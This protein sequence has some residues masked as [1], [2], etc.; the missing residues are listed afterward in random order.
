MRSC[1]SP[2]LQS[3]YRGSPKT[4]LLHDRL[5]NMSFLRQSTCQIFLGRL[6]DFHYFFT[7]QKYFIY[8]YIFITLKITAESILYRS[9]NSISKYHR[10]FSR[11]TY[12][13]SIAKVNHST[14]MKLFG[15]LGRMVRSTLR[16]MI[17]SYLTDG[18]TKRTNVE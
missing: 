3:H 1:S 6:I 10:N 18:I 16:R 12:I 15:V 11:N 17:R 9:Y 14:N 4:G 13:S 5:T 2:L 7:I 8:I